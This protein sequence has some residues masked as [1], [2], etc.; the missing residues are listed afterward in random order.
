MNK[1]RVVVHEVDG[2]RIGE[3]Y[4]T[5]MRREYGHDW[6]QLTINLLNMGQCRPTTIDYGDCAE[7]RS[8]FKPTKEM[9]ETFYMNYAEGGHAP[10]HQFTNQ[11]DALAEAARLA[12]NY[13]VSVYTLKAVIKTKPKHDVVTEELQE[14]ALPEKAGE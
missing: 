12:S 2:P 10:T 8:T 1:N 3:G 14:K 7:E 13:K 6:T 4:I 5:E 11:A 9:T